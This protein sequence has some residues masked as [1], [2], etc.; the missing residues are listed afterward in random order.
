M[1]GNIASTCVHFGLS[2]TLLKRFMTK[3]EFPLYMCGP[4]K[5]GKMLLKTVKWSLSRFHDGDQFTFLREMCFETE[6]RVFH[7]WRSTGLP[8][9]QTVKI[10]QL[11]YAK[12]EP[13]LHLK[14][15][16][17]Y[18][19][20]DQNFQVTNLWSKTIQDVGQC[21]PRLSKDC[22][23]GVPPTQACHAGNA[24]HAFWPQGALSACLIS[25][26]RESVR[27]LSLAACLHDYSPLRSFTS[28]Y[29]DTASPAQWEASNGLQWK[30]CTKYPQPFPSLLWAASLYVRGSC[31]FKGLW[32][33]WTSL[34]HLISAKHRERNPRVVRLHL[35]T[36]N[37]I[38]SSLHF[39]HYS[40]WTSFQACSTNTP[41][42]FPW[43]T[44]MR[45]L[46]LQ[47]REF[48]LF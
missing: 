43:C 15:K 42:S 19:D 28:Q 44:L 31:W 22:Y 39:M 13:L 20:G 7:F 24:E 38:C 17:L 21:S 12:F 33:E 4:L 6:H 16:V 3:S 35:E 26:E 40:N 36:N 37:I 27:A 46:H 5:S 18:T 45:F 23:K 47:K 11:Y 30:H 9:A 34:P 14:L 8:T 2:L 41:L 29:C 10:S 32:L 25:E 1:V 48:Q